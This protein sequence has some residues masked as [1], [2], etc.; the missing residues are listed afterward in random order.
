MSFIAEN[1]KVILCDIWGVIHNGVHLFDGVLDFLNYCKKNNI[2]V[3]LFSNAPRRA[4]T[5]KDF[6]LNKFNLS[7]DLYYDII[8][9]GEVFVNT[10]KDLFKNTKCFYI[11]EDK[12]LSMI[13][14]ISAVQTNNTSEADF[15]LIVGLYCNKNNE[16]LDNL[17]QELKNRNVIAHC[18]NP[19]LKVIT[20]GIEI[21]CAGFI[22]KKYAD[23]GGKVMWYGKPYK[24]IY[25]YA[26]DKVQCSKDE[27][28]AIGDSLNNDIAGANGFGIKSVLIL[29][30]NDK[31]EDILD[32]KPTLIVDNICE[33]I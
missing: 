8:T 30:G 5:V 18:P 28:L 11:G 25:Q 19:D 14:E 16:N 7:S 23:I 2:K 20:N 1:I 31:K 24:E 26:S 15:A 12:D 17:L 32:H 21:K 27:I 3:V 33:L 13:R 6:L 9:S 29:T 10:K 22:G 4:Q